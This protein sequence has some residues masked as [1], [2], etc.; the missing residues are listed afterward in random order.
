MCLKNN[1]QILIGILI[2]A[3]LFYILHKNKNNEHFVPEYNHQKYLNHYTDPNIV[4]YNKFLS[5]IYNQVNIP[6]EIIAEIQNI[7]LN[8][9]CLRSLNNEH[10]LIVENDIIGVLSIKN[11]DNP[12][13]IIVNFIPIAVK[14]TDK[15]LFQTDG[16][17]VAYTN[18]NEA[19]W[20]TKT[21]NKK[22]NHLSL[23][24]MGNIVFSE[25]HSTDNRKM[26]FNINELKQRALTEFPLV[27]DKTIQNPLLYKF[28]NIRNEIAHYYNFIHNKLMSQNI[29]QNMSQ[30]MIKSFADNNI[31]RGIVL[32]S[33][34]KKHY[35]GAE[36]GT[37]FLAT[38]T[39]HDNNNITINTKSVSAKFSENI[40]FQ[41]DGN[42]VSYTNQNKPLWNTETY[43][44]GFDSL[45][46]DNY[47]NIVI[48]NHNRLNEKEIFS[49]E[50]II[51][52]VPAEL[53]NTI[54]FIPSIN[55][56]SIVIQEA[57]K[58]FEVYPAIHAE[59]HQHM[60]P[61]LHQQMHPE[62]HQQMH[63]EMH[64]AM[65][66]AIQHSDSK[67]LGCYKDTSVRAIPN[68]VNNAP[69]MNKEQCENVA[70]KLNHKY[71]SLQSGGFCFTG[72]DGTDYAKY[73]R[74]EGCPENGGPW[75]NQVYEINNEQIN[76]STSHTIQS[77][78]MQKPTKII[79]PKPNKIIDC[80]YYGQPKGWYDI[81]NQG[82]K[83]DFCRYVG[84]SPEW[85]SCMIA[86]SNQPYTPREK[87]INPNL[88]HDPFTGWNG[89]AM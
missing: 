18:K 84:D 37:L 28:M 21:Y 31:L 46:L 72:P 26:T 55:Q 24:D 20:N 52:K 49:I 42:L 83:N 82:A 7:H 57:N 64:Q 74:A 33:P 47:G 81:N 88:P 6:T 3:V 65:H 4:L 71:Y 66:Q 75:E 10:Y 45:T 32:S 43:N 22:L 67:Y 30:Q 87:V 62:L 19:L 34:N 61:E 59:M 11:Q 68:Q 89:C 16:N 9:A 76:N 77:V 58:L 38:I 12:S 86:G 85:F 23:D 54:E 25:L 27:V 56:F 29:S 17:L 63:P 50:S 8:G 15:Y 40:I 73:G 70:K 53:K 36:N 60:H 13:E 79:A 14:N 78:S 2:L 48:Y 5:K 69:N 44:K 35:L 39:T 41:T 1:I 51:E 80:G